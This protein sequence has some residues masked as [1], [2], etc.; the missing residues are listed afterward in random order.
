MAEELIYTD[1]ESQDDWVWP[2]IHIK[3]YGYNGTKFWFEA[4]RQCPGGKGKYAF[5]SEEA[6][7]LFKMIDDAIERLMPQ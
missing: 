1:D 3:E 4:G 2:L 5:Y 7:Q 6:V